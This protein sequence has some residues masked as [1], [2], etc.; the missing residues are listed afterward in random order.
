[1]HNNPERLL[2]LTVLGYSLLGFVCIKSNHLQ[3]KF[4][5]LFFNLNV[6]MLYCEIALASASEPVLNRS[7]QCGSGLISDLRGNTETWSV[8]FVEHLS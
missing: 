2:S 6:P 8:I 5:L 7:R 4:I 3:T 1:M